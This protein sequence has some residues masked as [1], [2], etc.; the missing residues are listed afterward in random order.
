MNTK[1]HRLPLARQAA[2][3]GV[4][5][6]SI[7]YRP[8]PAADGDL[9]LMRRLDEVHLEM[10]WFGARGLRR[11]LRHEWPGVGRRRITTCLRRM[12][13]TALTPQPGTSA[14]HQAPPVHPYLLRHL[15]I[16]Q[17]NHVWAMDITYIPMARGFVYLAP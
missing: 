14:R 2:A 6:R 10:P 13:I 1:T 3:L 9:A 11:L 7:D 15:A 8:R 5:R 16:T 17:P 4:S 12:G